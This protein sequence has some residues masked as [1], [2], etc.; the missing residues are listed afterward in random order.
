MK[1]KLI[2]NSKN[3]IRN[4]LQTVMLNRGVKNYEEYLELKAHDYL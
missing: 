3:D 1:H 2:K 4:V